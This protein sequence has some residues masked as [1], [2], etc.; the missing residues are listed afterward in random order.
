VERTSLQ[1]QRVAAWRVWQEDVS[2]RPRGDWA[3][4]GGVAVHTTGIGVRHWNGAHLTDPAGLERLTHVERWFGSRGM[5]WGLLVPDELALEPAGMTL[6]T[7]QRVMLRDL[8]ALPE[9]PDVEL[10]WT[11][12]AAAAEVQAAAFGDDLE[13]T[14][15]FV[16]PKLLN[17][18]SAVVTGYD[19]SRPVSTATVFVV[20][21]VA[22][23]FGVATLPAYRRQGLGRAL[24]LAALHEGRRRGADLAYLNP[25]D[26]GEPVYRGL[27][28]EDAP[29]FR[30][31]VSEP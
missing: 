30:V 2:T 7:S 10:R 22:A 16:T 19:G 6:L 31:W 5:P 4:L 23:V 24:T 8:T 25:T 28:F 11:G 15:Q 27:A 26:S 12:A 17:S 1:R 20:D 21:G 18:A 29:P 14:R 13:Q 9:V 3:D